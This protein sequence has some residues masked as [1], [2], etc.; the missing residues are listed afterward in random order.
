MSALSIRH[1]YGAPHG[2]EPALAAH[3]NRL[4]SAVFG[5]AIENPKEAASNILL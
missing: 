1:Q 2:I 3:P 5:S 4:I